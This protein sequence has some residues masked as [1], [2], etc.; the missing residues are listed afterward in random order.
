MPLDVNALDS[1]S[2]TLDDLVNRLAVIATDAG[3]DDEIA[4][5]LR[6]VGRQLETT[7]RRLVKAVVRARR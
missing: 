4:I 5:E 2:A 1:L 3:D 7:S 6:E